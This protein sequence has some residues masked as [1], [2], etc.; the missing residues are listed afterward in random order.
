MQDITSSFVFD[1][2]TSATKVVPLPDSDK[3][4]K[5]LCR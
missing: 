4:R 3:L 2:M 5:E 1:Q